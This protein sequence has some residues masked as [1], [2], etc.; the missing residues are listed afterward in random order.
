MVCEDLFYERQQ[1]SSVVLVRLCTIVLLGDSPFVIVRGEQRGGRRSRL[2]IFSS[3]IA[4]DLLLPSQL[5]RI[6]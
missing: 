2:I 3:R 1:M 4:E 6:N 5:N